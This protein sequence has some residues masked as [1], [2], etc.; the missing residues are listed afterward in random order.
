MSV[1]DYTDY[2]FISGKNQLPIFNKIITL[3]KKV[4]P[5]FIRLQDDI[6]F[7]LYELYPDF[8]I[9]LLNNKTDELIGI[10][11]TIPLIWTK[12]LSEL[13][14]DGVSWVINT[15]INEQYDVASANVLCAISITIADHH[16]NKGISKILLQYLKHIACYKKYIS[17]IVP[18]RPTLKSLYPLISIDKYIQWTNND[19]LI[20][21]PW[22]R[23]HVALGAHILDVCNRSACITASIEQW[24]AWTGVPFPGDGAYVIKDALAPVYIVHQKNQGTYIE[25]NVWVSYPIDN[26][27]L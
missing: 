12:P 25:P 8:Q 14:N 23:I 10:V 6:V 5:D 21:D 18:V 13:S 1:H 11:N 3:R 17:L 9:G 15:G 24:E 7:K 2:T 20:F 27:K 19:G 22:L 16:R 4:W 26:V